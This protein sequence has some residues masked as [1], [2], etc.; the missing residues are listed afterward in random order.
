M[1]EDMIRFLEAVFT[2]LRC[3][4]QNLKQEITSLRQDIGKK[5]SLLRRLVQR[6]L[7]VTP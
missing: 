2:T 3:E 1:A 6:M 7:L 5:G 4:N